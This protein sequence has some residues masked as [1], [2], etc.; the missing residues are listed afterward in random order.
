MATMA[1]ELK[2]QTIDQAGMEVMRC[3][4]RLAVTAARKLKSA[5]APPSDW[6]GS[7]YAVAGSFVEIWGM[8]VI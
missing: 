2:E 6:V 8:S 3:K 5:K 4:T 1:A 7:Q